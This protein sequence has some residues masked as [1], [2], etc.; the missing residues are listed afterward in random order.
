MILISILIALIIER[1]ATKERV[2]QIATYSDKYVTFSQKNSLLKQMINNQVGFYVWL[3]LP[4]IALHFIAQVLDFILFELAIN[5]VVLL[6]CIGCAHLRRCYKDYLNALQRSDNEAA[7]L[8]AMQLGQG[9]L[10]SEGNETVGQ[11]IAWINFTHYGAVLFW[12]VIFGAEGAL[13]YSLL[14]YCAT[15][16]QSDATSLLDRHSQK[17]NKLQHIVD[18]LP[19]R[20]I[21]LG[22]L[23]IGNFTHGT[24]TWLKHAFDFSISNRRV[25]SDIAHAAEKVEEQFIGCTFEARCMV[26]LVKRNMLLFLGV[27]AFL[28]LFGVI[29]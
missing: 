17:I 15:S 10:D 6:V 13:T 27:I 18:W 28:T 4:V 24:S 20:I 3:L 11:T 14:R 1:L 26:K 23:I 19:A 7:S 5:V 21:S 22:Y 8:H 25:V 29:G 2:W 16:A 12:F 9:K